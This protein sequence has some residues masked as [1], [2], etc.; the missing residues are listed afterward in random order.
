[1]KAL[2]AQLD[3][4]S[5]LARINFVTTV[6]D[7]LS[8]FAM[9]SCADSMGYP[10]ILIG[11]S[12]ALKAFA[13]A[14]GA[15]TVP[16]CIALFSSRGGILGTQLLSLGLSAVTFA[17]V[18]T[19]HFDI[20]VFFAI[21]IA[22][23]LLKQVFDGSRETHSKNLAASAPQRGLQAQISFS[24]YGAQLIGPVLAFSL[25][26]WTPLWVPLGLDVVSFMIAVLLS[27]RL[28][29]GKQGA[30]PSNIFRPLFSYLWEKT[31]ERARLRRVFFVRSFGIWS[32]M[33]LFNYLLFDAVSRNFGKDLYFVTWIYASIGLGGALGAT[34][35][36]DR[37]S[38]LHRNL[39]DGT[40]CLI[41]N[42]GFVAMILTLVSIPSFWTMIVFMCLA[43]IGMSLNGIASQ[44]VRR[45][46]TSPSEFPEIVGLEMFSGRLISDF[47][48]CLIAKETMARGIL[49]TN[50]WIYIGA[51]LFLLNAIVSLGLNK[52]GSLSPKTT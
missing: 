14:I 34:V 35:L 23:T 39:G 50:A 8:Y 45:E 32:G 38:E 7:F 33:G 47:G 9:L 44:T 10:A 24:L 18:L 43:G 48:L 40:L 41:G 36:K 20:Y 17:M 49:S 52:A 16:R 19:G 12:V 2:K 13:N 21:T 11:F 22:Q 31:P 27:L 51:A 1:M 4:N 5:L 42:L 29:P 46:S 37:F 30:K 6:G 28:S 26:K 3:E 15:A 25:I